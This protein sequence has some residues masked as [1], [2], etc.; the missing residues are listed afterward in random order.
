MLEELVEQRSQLDKYDPKYDEATVMI[1]M[2]EKML[3][4]H[5]TAARV[6]RGVWW[7]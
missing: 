6:E 4:A 3:V 7:A 2:I 5:A 1:G